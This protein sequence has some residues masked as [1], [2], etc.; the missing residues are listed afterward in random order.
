MQ[1]KR[2]TTNRILKKKRKAVNLNTGNRRGRGGGR[3]LKKRV[4]RGTF[5]G[6]GGKG[7]GLT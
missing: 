3:V 2:V 7:K 6:K 1:K 4:R 5:R